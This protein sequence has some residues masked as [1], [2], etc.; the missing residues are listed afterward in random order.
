MARMHTKKHGK[1]KSRKPTDEAAEKP[2]VAQKEVEQ[3]IVAYA[4]QG[5]HQA[6]G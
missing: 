4:K 3:I 6:Q 1:S 5:M 2:T